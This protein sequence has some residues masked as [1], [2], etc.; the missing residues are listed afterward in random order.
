MKVSKNML[1][2][3][4]VAALLVTLSMPFAAEAK[5]GKHHGKKAHHSQAHKAKKA[6]KAK[7][8][9]TETAPEAAP[10]MPEAAPA[11]Q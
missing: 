8:S 3:M 7:A 10:G 1:S 4:A 11:G 6:K 9:S 5:K 2:V